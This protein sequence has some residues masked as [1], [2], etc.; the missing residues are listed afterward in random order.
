M[1]FIKRQWTS[2][3]W[4]SL[5]PWVRDTVTDIPLNIDWSAKLLR[6]LWEILE[7]LKSSCLSSLGQSEK[8]GWVN[9]R[10]EEWKNRREISNC[11]KWEWEKRGVLQSVALLGP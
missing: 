9:F 1:S 4:R 11:E 2:P 6:F 3:Q 8:T 10:A 5:S 7:I